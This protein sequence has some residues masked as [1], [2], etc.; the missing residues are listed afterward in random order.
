MVM[1]DMVC[2]RFSLEEVVVAHFDHGIRENSAEDAEFV[3]RK[4]VE[5]GAEFRSGRAELGAG[6][7][8]AEA[9]EK[10]YEFLGQLADELDDGRG[11]EIWTA[12]HLDDLAETV[13]INF[14][15]G[16]GWRGLSALDKPGVRRPF[17]ETE[18]IYEPMDKAAIFEYAA[19]RR[20]AYREDPSNSWDE[21]L[22]NRIRH[23]MN[24]GS[25]RANNTEAD[26]ESQGGAGLSFEQ[27]LKIWQLWQRQK[28]LKAE[29]DRLVV[30]L[31][32]GPGEEWER[33]WFR[34]LD[35]DELSRAVAIELL[36]AGTIRAGISATRP[37]LENFR[38]AIIDYLPGKSFNL[39]EDKLVK[40][41]KEGFRL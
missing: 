13:A 38:R 30:G 10:R 18:L 40:F 6:A 16:T 25:E 22:R 28:D 3:R 31:M 9:R 8:E 32:P 33:K 19:K 11:V 21:Y 24:N 14:L 4:A 41:T 26:F 37:Q 29:I 12:H 2:R 39:P 20:L 15:R 23:Q 27:K 17:L 34:E 5:Y 36:R 35:E 7:S 1:L